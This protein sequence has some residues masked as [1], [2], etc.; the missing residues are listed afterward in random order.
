MEKWWDDYAYLS[1][2]APLLPYCTMAMPLIIASANVEESEEYALKGAA[3]VIYHGFE[4]YD[5][6]RKEKLKPSAN[7]D[8]SV[9]FSSYLFK[10]FYN[11]V[12]IPGEVMDEVHCYFKTG[13]YNWT[14]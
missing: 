14:T 11:T 6:I 4:F 3:R 1:F 5:L 7:P 10:R 9:T 8:G 12:R 2:R 13:M